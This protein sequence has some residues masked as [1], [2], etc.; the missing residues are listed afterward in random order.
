VNRRAKP[1]PIVLVLDLVLG[2]DRTVRQFEDEDE[3]EYDLIAA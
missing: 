2:L 3:D 1:Q